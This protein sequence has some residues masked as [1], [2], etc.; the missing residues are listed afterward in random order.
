MD[1]KREREGVR[2]KREVRD[3]EMDKTVRFEREEGRVMETKR[4]E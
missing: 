1:T 4:Q 2:E 3:M